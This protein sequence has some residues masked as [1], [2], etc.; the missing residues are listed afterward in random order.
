MVAALVT[1]KEAQTTTPNCTECERVLFGCYMEL[2]LQET[3]S[4]GEEV[5]EYVATVTLAILKRYHNMEITWKRTDI[6]VFSFP[7]ACIAI[8]SS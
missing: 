4:L 2:G 3:L 8:W 7:N 6:G 1:E 5:A